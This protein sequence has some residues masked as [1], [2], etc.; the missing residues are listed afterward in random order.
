MDRSAHIADEMWG[1]VR[2]LARRVGELE[3]ADGLGEL[4]DEGR[5]RLDALRLRAARA[6]RRA[7]LADEL[8][9]RLAGLRPSG[10]RGPEGDADQR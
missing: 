4:D 5:A 3:R 10:P 2:E 6:A 9:D 1:R 7:G 8:S